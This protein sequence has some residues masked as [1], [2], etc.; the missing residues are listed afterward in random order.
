MC[1]LKVY[2]YNQ[3][4]GRERARENS[5]STLFYWLP[6]RC[7]G[8]HSYHPNLRDLGLTPIFLEDIRQEHLVHI[9]QMAFISSSSELILFWRIFLSFLWDL[10]EW[11]RPLDFFPCYN[12]DHCNHSDILVLL[13]GWHFCW[14]KYSVLKQNTEILALHGKKGYETLRHFNY[15]TFATLWHFRN[16]SYSCCLSFLATVII[17][18]MF[19]YHSR[20]V[21][22]LSI[23]IHLISWLSSRRAFSLHHFLYCLKI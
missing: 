19:D 20:L 15:T 18:G 8:G 5:L 6:S 21:W 16:C 22:H 23:S 11:N 2:K 13:P 1:H 14:S 4:W 7:A 17:Q 10:Q 3:C 9:V 12:L